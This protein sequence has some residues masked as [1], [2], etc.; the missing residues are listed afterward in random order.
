[1]VVSL[2]SGF[3]SLFF[4]PKKKKKTEFSVFFFAPVESQLFVNKDIAKLE[5]INI[6]NIS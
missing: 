2:Y 1:M 3:H 5:I 6:V 4:L